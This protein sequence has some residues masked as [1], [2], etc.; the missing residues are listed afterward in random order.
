MDIQ[1]IETEYHG[2]KF[3]SRLEARWAVF[4]DRMNIK[5]QY[6]HEGYKTSSGYYVPDF[7]LTNV[8]MRSTLIK[9]VLFEVKPESYIGYK[10]PALTEVAE[11]LHV[12]ATLAV[13][14]DFTRW[15]TWKELFQVSPGWDNCMMIYRCECKATK[16]D[17]DEGHYYQCPVCGKAEGHMM[18]S[19]IQEAYDIALA[20]RFW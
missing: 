2:Y 8:Y 19:R 14:F 17:Y 3:R 4:F 13:G 7:W 18:G 12:G 1:P 11:Y 5:W 15:S 6:E 16:F 20:Y 9:G 10:H